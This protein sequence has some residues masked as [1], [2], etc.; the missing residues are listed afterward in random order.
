MQPVGATDQYM[1]PDRKNTFP[2]PKSGK[3]PDALSPPER[4]KEEKDFSSSHFFRLTP[5]ALSLIQ[6]VGAARCKN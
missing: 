2:H 4:I 1:L 6:N 5:L 3:Y